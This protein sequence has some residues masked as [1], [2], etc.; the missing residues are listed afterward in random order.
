MWYHSV[1]HGHVPALP[2]AILE[3]NSTALFGFTS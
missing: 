2:Y 1:G 3:R